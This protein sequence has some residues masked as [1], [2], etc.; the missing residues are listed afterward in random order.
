TLFVF[1]SDHSHP[2]PRHWDHNQPEFRK[3]IMAF[4]GN[5]IRPEFKGYRYHKIC[6]QIDFASTLLHQLGMPSSGFEWSKDL[7]N[8]YT[9]EFAYFEAIDR[10]GWVRP[11]QYIFYAHD[12]RKYYLEKVN[13][14]EEE[15]RLDKEGKS[16]LQT[17]F[18][19][20]T[21]Y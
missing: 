14:E 16:Y 4:W 6:S 1:I 17:V 19:E 10:F 13:S 21:D 2:S 3:I 8:P 11:G 7:F 15:K 9:S 5:V 20:Y 18:Q 12:L